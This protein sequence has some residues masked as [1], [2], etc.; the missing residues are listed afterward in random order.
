LAMTFTRKAAAEMR[1]RIITM[2]HDRAQCGEIQPARWRHLRDRLGDVTISTIDAFCLS[3]LREFPLQADLDPG[4]ARALQRP[5]SVQHRLGIR[6]FPT[7][8][9]T[10]GAVRR[11]QHSLA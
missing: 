5:V 7:V 4:F 8:A 11:L 10:G 6:H 2:L 9:G 3:L 1:E